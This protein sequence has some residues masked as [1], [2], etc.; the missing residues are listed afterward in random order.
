MNPVW[1]RMLYG[2]THMATGGVKGLH[3]VQ[4]SVSKV[5]YWAVLSVSH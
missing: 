1:H 3:I 4:F 5:Y 2:S